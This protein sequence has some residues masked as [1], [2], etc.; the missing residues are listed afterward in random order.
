MTKQR[1]CFEFTVEGFV[2]I[3]NGNAYGKKDYFPHNGKIAILDVKKFVASLSPEQLSDYC[4]FLGDSSRNANMQ[5]FLKH[6]SLQKVAEKSIAYS[7]ESSLA[8]APRGVIQYYD[9][10]EFVKDAY[11]N[12]YV[13]G[14]SVKG[15]LR[16]AL[17]NN[18]ILS[19]PELLDYY[20]ESLACGRDKHK[21]GKQLE[22]KAFFLEQPDKNNPATLNDIMKYISVS[23][24][25][26]LSCNDLVFVKKYDKFSRA[27]DASHKLDMKSKT[28][29]KGNSLN[30]YRECLRPSTKVTV[31]VDVDSRINECL[32]LPFTLDIKGLE[33]LFMRSHE[34]YKKCFLD[35]FDIGDEANANKEKSDGK[36][37]YVMTTGILAG[38]RC[39][40]NALEGSLFCNAHQDQVA[41]NT[42]TSLSNSITCYLGGG[43][44][45]DSKTV[46]NALFHDN[47]D[48]VSKIAHILYEQFPT[49]VDTNYH[50][51]LETEVNEAGYSPRPFHARF[52]KNG[53]IDKA[54]EDHRHWRDVEF[55]VAPHTMK[56]GELNK[57]KLPMG[58]CKVEIKEMP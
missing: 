5:E 9:V 28:N 44:D 26:P 13:P 17:L 36:C 53:R 50:A 30:I 11:G 1:Y 55:G 12:P 48:R 54:K 47:D 34:L 3:G 8:R 16:T 7:V 51:A 31:T 35:A 20:D 6:S 4:D 39:R 18:L 57:N 2:H 25:E 33:Q 32:H 58:K 27:D 43:V 46:M 52:K 56:L 19:Q 14:S 38:H 42:S 24:S 41:E 29:D 15:M 49:R 10:W 21:A 40:N 23:D 37:H 22:K 45:F